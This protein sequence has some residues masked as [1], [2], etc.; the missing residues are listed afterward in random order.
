MRIAPGALM[1]PVLCLA[2]APASIG[3]PAG[4]APAGDPAAPPTPP[5]VASAGAHP[6]A[7]A[8]AVVAPGV[9]GYGGVPAAA[10]TCE[11]EQEE[12]DGAG[13]A[14]AEGAA[15]AVPVDTPEGEAGPPDGQELMRRA[16]AV[17]DTLRTLRA[18]FHQSIEM[19]VFEPP[20]EREG[21]GTWYQEKPSLFRMDFSDPEGDLIVSDGRHLWLYYPSTHPGQVIRSELGARGR[22]AAMADLQGRIFR[23][24]R[25]RY[26]VRYAGRDT[27]DGA[28]VHRVELDPR[29]GDADYRRV[30]VWL[31]AGSLLV[32]RLVFE[33][34]GETV[35]TV[36]LDDIRT[37]LSLPDSLFRFR[38]PEGTEVFEG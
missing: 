34:R 18:R 33:D 23:L 12:E 6:A 15:G 25:T 17:Y 8:P 37:G 21:S 30:E 7:A 27:L 36:T 20:R 28:P 26:D 29:A 31:D 24:A 14:A 9:A 32:R 1:L 10:D 11:Q 5:I 13:R 38:V 35:R 2:A 19:R 4:A 16:E 3:A 22:G